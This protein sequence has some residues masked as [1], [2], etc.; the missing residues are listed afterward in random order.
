MS[1][2]PINS[3]PKKN[4]E[5][6]NLAKILDK[7]FVNRKFV[8]VFDDAI[9]R[10]LVNSEKAPEGFKYIFILER[11]QGTY[12]YSYKFD[13]DPKKPKKY[14]WVYSDKTQIPLKEVR[15]RVEKGTD[16]L[17][18]ELNDLIS[19]KTMDILLFHINEI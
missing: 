15:G 2:K 10:L 18:E 1:E 19:E 9:I 4:L 8:Y 7:A 16:E 6:H 12:R 17:L 13:Y 3:K 11:P 5:N 14:M